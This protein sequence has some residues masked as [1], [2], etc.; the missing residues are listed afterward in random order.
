[1]SSELGRPRSLVDELNSQW[2]EAARPVEVDEPE[3]RF[4]GLG[5]RTGFHP[6]TRIV[7]MFGLPA[8]VPLEELVDGNDLCH[9][10]EPPLNRCARSPFPHGLRGAMLYH[11]VPVTLVRQPAM[12]SPS[13]AR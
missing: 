12:Q 10:S 13:S 1:M 9:A 6:Q 11:P 5:E 2:R 8:G 4:V 3:T 7:E